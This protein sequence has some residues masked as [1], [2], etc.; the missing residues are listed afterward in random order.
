MSE[1]LL[2][3]K[4]EDHTSD[5]ESDDGDLYDMEEDPPYNS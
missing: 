1:S 2:F 3:Q 5:M 4:N